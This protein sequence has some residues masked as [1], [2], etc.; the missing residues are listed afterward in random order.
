[1]TGWEWLGL[2]MS[3]AFVYLVYRHVTRPS[4][5]L[6]VEQ[7]EEKIMSEVEKPQFDQLRNGNWTFPVKKDKNG[8]WQPATQS[9]IPNAI[10]QEIR[11]DQ[12]LL[13]EE[14]KANTKANQELLAY[15]KQ[16]FG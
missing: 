7:P 16:V 8:V 5:P 14:L 13:F 1:M 10:L 6:G 11:D 9:S 2:S 12:R 15:L 3:L 4:P